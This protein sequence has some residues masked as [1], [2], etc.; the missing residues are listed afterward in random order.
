MSIHILYD[1]DGKK[2]ARFTIAKH[3]EHRDQ[4]DWGGPYDL[5][6]VDDDGQIVAPPA[7]VDIGFKDRNMFVRFHVRD[8]IF[9]IDTEANETCFIR[10]NKKRVMTIR[11][12]VNLKVF[13][14]KH[15]S[16][17]E[18]E[19]DENED[20]DEDESESESD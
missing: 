18:D 4:Y 3:F 5:W 14:D 6:F 11:P 19:F 9:Y 1:S 12:Y 8:D 15:K 10:F 17:D 20:E 13:Y 7:N 16:D 2:I